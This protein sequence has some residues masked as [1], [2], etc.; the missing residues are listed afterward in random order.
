[1]TSVL[2]FAVMLVAQA[3]EDFDHDGVPDIEDDCPTDPG[4]KNNKGC[5]GEKPKEEPPPDKPRID[6]KDDRIELKDTILFKTGSATIDPRSN[7]LIKEI[8]EGIKKLPDGKNILI[9]G[10]T[11][12]VG[13]K[14]MNEQLSEKRAQAVVASL[15][16]YGVARE[17]LAAQGFGP[18]KPIADNKTEAGRMKNRRVEFL[19]KDA[20]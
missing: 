9:A 3:P 6:V 13:S 18:N 19:I 5:P 8:A 15:V 10:H 4:T 14:K 11:D 1:M 16:H 7:S 12:N 17:R 2:L 20:H